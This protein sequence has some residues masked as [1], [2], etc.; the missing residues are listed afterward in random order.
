MLNIVMPTEL[1][2]S[3]RPSSGCDQTNTELVQFRCLFGC[4]AEWRWWWGCMFAHCCSLLHYLI[5]SHDC[6]LCWL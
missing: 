6:W 1:W 5:I 2:A 3:A 4:C